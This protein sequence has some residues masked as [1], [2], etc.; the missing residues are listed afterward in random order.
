[1][2]ESN[3]KKVTSKSPTRTLPLLKNGDYYLAGTT[4]IMWYIV[5]NDEKCGKLLMG[6]DQNEAAEVCMWLNHTINTIWPFYDHIIG[7]VTGCSP[8]NQEVF[9]HACEDLMSTLGNVNDH[10]KFKSF[11]VG[12]GLTLA[13]L[14][15]AVSLYPYFSLVLA[16]ECR[17]KISNVTR[18]YLFAANLKQFQAV[19]GKPRL[20]PVSHKPSEIAIP[21][22][23]VKEESKEQGKKDQKPKD[24]QT[25]SKE[26]AKPKEPAKPKDV[27]P[28]EEET[29]ESAEL[30]DEPKQEKKANPLDKL[31][32][33]TF[34]LDPFKKEFLNTKERQQVL[35]VFWKK[36]DP[37]GFS[38]WFLHYNKSGD[39]GKLAFKTKNLRSN[40][41][42]KV[43]KFRKYTFAVHGVYGKEP[44]LEVE[45]VWMWRGKDIPE[46]VIDI[47][48]IDRRT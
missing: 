23:T 35:N 19:L 31:P 9:N 25:K 33:S 21:A 2:S 6:K 12:S 41:L 10:L 24:Q 30:G 16:D 44:D 11:L 1:M 40:F 48:N 22:K 42:Q 32:P 26:T 8:C 36:F 34:E 29:K 3:I 47:L 20:C 46:E 15:L 13:D 14:F 43:D 17:T 37:E 28:K 5:M 38:I 45:G 7:Q 27:K 39:Q 4:A 18:L